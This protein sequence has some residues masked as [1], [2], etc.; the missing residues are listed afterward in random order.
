M[1]KI[2]KGTGYDC[3]GNM[4]TDGERT[5]T[6]DADNKPVSMTQGGSA[7]SFPSTWLGTGPSTWL[8]TGPSTWLGTGPSTWL[9][10]GPST[11]LGTGPSTWLGTGP[12]TWLGTGAYSGDGAREKKTSLGKTIPKSF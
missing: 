3:N 12:S 10:T 4:L 6:W 11:W 1:F 9:G 2:L 7:T 5:F 8:G